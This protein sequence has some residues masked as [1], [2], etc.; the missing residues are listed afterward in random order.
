MS[1]VMLVE[2]QAC[3]RQALGM[4]LR[5]HTDFGIS[6]QAVSLAEGFACLSADKAE[7]IDAAIID[8]RL[9]DGNGVDLIGEIGA[10]R[11]SA[12]RILMMGPH[13]DPGPRAPRWAAGSRSGRDG[14]QGGLI[15][16]YPCRGE[17]PRAKPG[18][19]E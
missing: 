5:Q 8:I 1:H 12:S 4:E 3:F 15:R 6:T 2:N 7:Q 10:L 14:E 11:T 19:T 16:E 13:C 9:P 18:A 17:A